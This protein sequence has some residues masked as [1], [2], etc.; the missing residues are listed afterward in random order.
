MI[1][2]WLEEMMVYGTGCMSSKN[3]VHRVKDKPVGI[4]RKLRTLNVC[5]CLA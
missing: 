3:N 2:I 4:R 1:H 5:R